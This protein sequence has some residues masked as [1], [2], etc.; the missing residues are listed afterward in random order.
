MNELELQPATPETIEHL[1]AAVAEVFELMLGKTCWPVLSTLGFAASLTVTISLSGPIEGTCVLGL[2]QSAA[3]EAMEAMLGD[4]PETC[5]A[6]IED[7]ARELCNVIVGSW[8]NKLRPLQASALLS[9][10]VASYSKDL[11]VGE[12]RFYSFD[13]NLLTLALSI[14]EGEQNYLTT[15]WKSGELSSDANWLSEEE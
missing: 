8:K 7:A 10:P 4:H 14:R 5:D 1:D 13:G 3:R 15:D 11:V 6:M 9:L 2:S 12:R